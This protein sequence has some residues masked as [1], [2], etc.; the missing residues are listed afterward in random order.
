ML[1]P[2]E[3]WDR[4]NSSKSWVSYINAIF[5]QHLDNRVGLDEAIQIDKE[6]GG[7]A[8]TSL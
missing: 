7:E 4:S 1:S 3:R 2:P 8:Y 6:V 5:L